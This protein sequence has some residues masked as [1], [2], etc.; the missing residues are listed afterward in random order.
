MGKNST[1]NRVWNQVK[2]NFDNFDFHTTYYDIPFSIYAYARLVGY[3]NRNELVPKKITID[4]L[5]SSY[6]DNFRNSFS[7]NNVLK[8]NSLLF[9]YDIENLQL[10]ETCINE[11]RQEKYK[12]NAPYYSSNSRLNIDPLKKTPHTFFGNSAITCSLYLEFLNLYRKR[13]YGC[14]YGEECNYINFN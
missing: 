14:Y 13:F 2:K 9:F 7:L 1:N 10:M 12:E 5:Y 6:S 8:I 4:K 3:G 11:I